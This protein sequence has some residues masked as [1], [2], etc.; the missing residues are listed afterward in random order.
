ESTFEQACDFIPER[1]TS[2]PEMAKNKHASSPFSQG[3]PEN[4]LP[5]T[6]KITPNLSTSCIGK[7]LAWKN[8][9]Y[10]VALLISKD[11]VALAPGEDG[12]RI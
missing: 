7:V 9:S 10:V 5:S 6:A 4:K 2:R 8:I 1:W 11:D 12:T 3:M